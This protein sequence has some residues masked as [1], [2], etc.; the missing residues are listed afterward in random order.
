[1]IKFLHQLGL[2]WSFFSRTGSSLTRMCTKKSRWGKKNLNVC[3]GKRRSE[4]GQPEVDSN[5][6]IYF[7][8]AIFN[9]LSYRV[10]L[11]PSLL[12]SNRSVDTCMISVRKSYIVVI[13]S[14][15]FRMMLTG[16]APTETVLAGFYWNT[17]GQLLKFQV[18]WGRYL[19]SSSGLHVFFALR[20][21][22]VW[23]LFREWRIC[24]LPAVTESPVVDSNFS[25]FLPANR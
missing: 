6:R 7:T 14:D 18:T 9:Q 22:T 13:S 12:F 11:S 1:M 15:I 3:E 5:Y 20:H 10:F 19:T 17:V 8:A 4:W 21:Q 16:D 24:L 2:K 23:Y 25:L